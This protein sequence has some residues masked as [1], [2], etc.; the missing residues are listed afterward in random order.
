MGTR[1]PRPRLDGGVGG[2]RFGW[3]WG[4]R[5]LWCVSG[6]CVLRAVGGM[7]PPSAR[8]YVGALSGD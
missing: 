5:R 8:R 1:P 2:W 4:G 3:L 6:F 7:T